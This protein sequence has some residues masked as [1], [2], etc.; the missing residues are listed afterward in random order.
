MRLENSTLDKYGK[1]VFW[2]RTCTRKCNVPCTLKNVYTLYA[3][4]LVKVEK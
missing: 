4:V 1:G 3:H 2:W